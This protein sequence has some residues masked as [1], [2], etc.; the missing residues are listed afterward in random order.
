[1]NRRLLL[2]VFGA[3][4]VLTASLVSEDAV[5]PSALPIDTDA[6]EATATTAHKN[7]PNLK[8]ARTVD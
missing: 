7:P 8:A 2:L 6:E 1:M 4:A 3:A 5:S